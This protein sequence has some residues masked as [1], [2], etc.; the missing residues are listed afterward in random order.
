[1][2]APASPSMFTRRRAREHKLQLARDQQPLARDAERVREAMTCGARNYPQVAS[3]LPLDPLLPGA[4][5]PERRAA[6]QPAGGRLRAAPP[7]GKGEPFPRPHPP[8]TLQL[9]D[10]FNLGVRGIREG[11]KER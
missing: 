3:L 8:G 2:I 9:T 11:H 5:P 6:P 7:L 1:M 4:P 10:H